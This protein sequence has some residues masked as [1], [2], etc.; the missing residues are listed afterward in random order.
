M[1][2]DK[3]AMA[4]VWTAPSEQVAL[5]KIGDPIDWLPFEPREVVDGQFVIREAQNNEHDLA[6]AAEA[7]RTGFP[8]IRGTELE[9]LFKAE[10]FPLILGQDEQFNQG[11]YFMLL[12][13]EIATGKIAGAAII[14]MLKRQR[15]GEFVALTVHADF[16]GNGLGREIQTACDQYFERC[17]VEM[18]FVFLATEHPVTQRFSFEQGFHPVGI[19]HGYYRVWSGKDDLARRANCV[20][21]QKF[22]GGAEKMCPTEMVLLPQAERLLVPLIEH[23]PSDTI[24]EFL[25]ILAQGIP[26]CQSTGIF[27][28]DKRPDDTYISCYT[29][30]VDGIPSTCAGYQ[31]QPTDHYTWFMPKVYATKGAAPEDRL[32]ISDYDLIPDDAPLKQYYPPVFVSVA[33][34]VLWDGDEFLGW[35]GILSTTEPIDWDACTPFIV[36][37]VEKYKDALVEAYRATH[38]V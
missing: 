2:E 31:N 29:D 7:Y 9:I 24:T 16:Q 21:A 34:Y 8:V 27:F 36:E 12:A 35:I 10:G 26:N 6:G 28:A 33:D 37:T 20:L 38:S 4:D 32:V 14:R 3:Q 17:G 30:Y 18:A 19:F 13:E 23:Y 15:N 22:Y 11:D 5:R 25:D 1:A